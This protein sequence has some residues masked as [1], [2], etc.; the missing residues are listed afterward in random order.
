MMKTNL[1]RRGAL[2]MARMPTQ[3]TMGTLDPGAARD[4]C[5]FPTQSHKINENTLHVSV[6][7]FG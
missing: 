7:Y 4:N 6:M 3:C 2:E 5:E 1:N